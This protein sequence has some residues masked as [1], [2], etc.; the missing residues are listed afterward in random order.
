MPALVD[1]ALAFV[2]AGGAAAQPRH[3]VLRKPV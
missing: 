3:D 1:T 2:I